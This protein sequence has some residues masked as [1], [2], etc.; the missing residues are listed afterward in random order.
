MTIMKKI[1][2]FIGGIILLASCAV[3]QKIDYSNFRV[4][5]KDIKANNLDLALLDHREVVISQKKK[6]SF[7]GYLRS[8]ADIPWGM[9]TKGHTDFIDDLSTGMIESFKEKNILGT[10]LKTSWTDNEDSVKRKLLLMN[11]DKKLF[12]V[13]HKLH[14]DGYGK[15]VLFYD[16]ELNIYGKSGI[17][18]RNKSFKGKTKLGGTGFWGPADYKTYTPEKVSEFFES[19]LSD[20]DVSTAINNN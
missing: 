14:T 9:N 13:F 5:V 10:K 15:Q 20:P 1:S 2:I 12:F 3:N 18:I 19:I 17:L 6:P 7:I 8:G 16:F 11:V 4:N